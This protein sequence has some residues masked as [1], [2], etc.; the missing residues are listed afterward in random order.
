VRVYVKPKLPPARPD[1]WGRTPQKHT[2]HARDGWQRY[3]YANGPKPEERGR[4]RDLDP[5]MK[6]G[7]LENGELDPAS[8]NVRLNSGPRTSRKQRAA[9]ERRAKERRRRKRS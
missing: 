7:I 2:G 9:I 6:T 5:V 8:R 4:L 3:V 1:P